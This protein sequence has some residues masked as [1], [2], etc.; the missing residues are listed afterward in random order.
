[1]IEEIAR[2]V[3]HTEEEMPQRSDKWREWRL[4]LGTATQAACVACQPLPYPGAPKTWD[5]QRDAGEPVFTAAQQRRIDHGVKYEDE[6][7]QEWNE[8]DEALGLD[9][10]PVCVERYL[11]SGAKIG[12]SLDAY[13]W[14]EENKTHRWLE[15]KCPD[16]H[17]SKVWQAVVEDRIPEDYIWQVAHQCLTLGGD[18][19]ENIEGAFLVYLP[20]TEDFD[21]DWRILYVDSGMLQ[22]EMKRLALLWP[23]YLDGANM[24]GDNTDIPAFIEAARRYIEA[25]KAK[26]LATDDAADLRK[27][28]LDII[29]YGDEEAD[30]LPNTFSGGGIKVSRRARTTFDKGAFELANPD[31]DMTPYMKQSTSWVITVPK[32]KKETTNG[33]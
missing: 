28:I 9:F 7:L 13:A 8:S 3:F 30:Y 22:D 29:S 24:P 14:D 15:I 10:Q 25:N 11:A 33:S 17:G 31:F 4:T 16:G 18:T 32:P 12:A 21:S 23:P 19:N 1:M 5:E 6:A 20:E 27:E 2:P 26:K